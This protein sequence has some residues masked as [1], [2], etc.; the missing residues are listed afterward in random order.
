MKKHLT[1]YKKEKKQ[2]IDRVI[3]LGDFLFK[4]S[5]V[6]QLKFHVRRESFRLQNRYLR[7]DLEYLIYQNKGVLKIE[8]VLSGISFF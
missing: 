6:L 7:W 8:S 5:I 4:W 2:T 1:K 3:E